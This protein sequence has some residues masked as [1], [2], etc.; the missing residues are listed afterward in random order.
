M[1]TKICTKCKEIKILTDFNKNKTRKDGH[2]NICRECSNLKSKEYYNDNR[3]KHKI[4]IGERNKRIRKEN[5][6]KYFDVLSQS[7]CIDCG[8]KD[9]IVLEFDHK[10]NVDKI[11][12]VGN[13]VN[14]GYSWGVILEEI[15]K[16]DVR[17][18]NCHRRRTAKQFNWYKDI[19]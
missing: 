3:E 4:I 6:R 12:G 15:K 2:S 5:Q 11:D 14:A 8:E 9:P 1:E 18:A 10:D 17:C 19:I 16:C 13:M 7:Y